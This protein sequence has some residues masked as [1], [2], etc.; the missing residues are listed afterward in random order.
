M[1]YFAGVDLQQF[2]NL[3][4]WWERINARPAVKRGVAVPNEPTITN[5]PYQ[6]RLKEE[7]E[8]KQ[9]EEELKGLLKKAKEQ[10]EYK[11]SAP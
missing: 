3:Y 2:P 7:P 10:Y 9:K 4:K 5:E 11:F 8:F 6:R 1:G